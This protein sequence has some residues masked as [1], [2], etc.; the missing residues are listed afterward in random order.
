MKTRV[1]FALVSA[2]A[3]A[4]S[5]CG[6]KT[7]EAPAA[8]PTAAETEAMTA[9]T[10][11]VDPAEAAAEGNDPTNNPIPPAAGEAAPAAE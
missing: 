6:G 4:L 8:E 3:L 7:E 5:A 9:E 10:P 1:T 11:A 2:G